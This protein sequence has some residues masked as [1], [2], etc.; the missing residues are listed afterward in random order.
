MGR[1]MLCSWLLQWSHVRRINIVLIV[2]QLLGGTNRLCVGRISFLAFQSDLMA[3]VN[4]YGPLVT[5]H[6][7]L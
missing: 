1:I 6:L 5:Q 4:H 2:L 7:E 3:S